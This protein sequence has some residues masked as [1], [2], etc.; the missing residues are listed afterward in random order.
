[1]GFFDDE[2]AALEATTAVREAGFAVHDVYSP[3]AMHG[4]SDAMGLKPSKLTWAC[5]GFGALGLCCG[6]GLQYYTSAV[7]WALNV[8]GKPFNSGPAFVPVAFELTVLLAG[9]GVV[10][11]LFVVSRIGPGSAARALPRTTDDRFA[12]AID[13]S[14]AHFEEEE[15]AR[16]LRSH[17]AVEMAFAEVSR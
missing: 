1:V 3:Y 14:A 5:F 9:L 13:T 4:I 10:A 7:S 8:G 6:A 2:H 15:A 12:V 11:S 17:G 16:V